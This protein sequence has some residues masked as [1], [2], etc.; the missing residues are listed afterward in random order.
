MRKLTYEY[1]SSFFKEKECELISKEY[2]A[3]NLNLEYRCLCGRISKI[4]FADFKKGVR[5]VDCGGTKRLKYNDVKLYFEMQGCCLIS[6]EYINNRTPLE[7][8][9]SCGGISKI[10]LSDFKRGQRCKKCKSEKT[11]IR[12]KKLPEG[13]I[14]SGI[15]LYDTFY[16]KLNK[17][18]E[19]YRDLLNEKILNVK[20]S[21]CGKIFRPSLK[22]VYARIR[23][24]NNLGKGE[25]RFYCSTECKDSCP[26]FL[27]SKYRKGES[28]LGKNRFGVALWR[29]MVLERDNYTCQKC[30]LVSPNGVGLEAHHYQDAVACAPVLSCDIDN[31]ITLC[32][33]C[34]VAAHQIEGCTIQDIKEAS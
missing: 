21:Q 9:C 10:R 27:K 1:V 20:C 7:F 14:K 2:F 26:V 4:R 3:S 12:N 5:C 16:W 8:K 28:P 23:A 31:G 32:E 34:H 18:E 13:V 29:N 24:I 22:G 19:C 6:K 15:P 33:K 25:C 30:G 11:T 17:I